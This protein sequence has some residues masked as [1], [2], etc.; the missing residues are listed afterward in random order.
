MKAEQQFL[1]PVH[2]SDVFFLGYALTGYEAQTAMDEEAL[3]AFLGCSTASLPRLALRGRPDPTSPAFRTDLQRLSDQFG[4]N[5][6]RLALLLR[7]LTEAGSI[8][9]DTQWHR[10]LTGVEQA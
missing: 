2:P 9:A 3:A 1:A 5:V 6:D 7:M 8:S 4:V 10:D